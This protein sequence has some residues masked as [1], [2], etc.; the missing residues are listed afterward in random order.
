MFTS[1]PKI[2]TLTFLSGIIPSL[3]W[4]WFW[5]KEDDKNSEPKSLLT[6]IFV[7]GM[8]SVVFV[9]P[10]EKFIQNN[11]NS[12]EIQI[13]LWSVT[14][15]VMKYL[16][17]LV[18]VYKTKDVDEPIDWPIYLITTALGFAAF[19]NMLFL[20]KP[21]SV[22]QSFVGLLTG[23]LRFLGSTLLHA[24]S[25][26]IIGIS[27]G[28]AFHMHALAKKI[29]LLIGLVIAILLHSV[30]NFF[31]MKNDGGDFLKVFSFLWVI[32]IIV[33]LLLEKLRRAN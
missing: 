13:L 30:F 27:L 33:M 10:I 29:H 24:V 25:S 1:D 32:T 11:I 23:Q 28:L 6:A 15:E 7:V 16:A 19:E 20:I 3:F 26:A 22:G 9:V 4:L 18:V 5:L 2:L 31:I 12:N 17:V 21:F 14:E 8:M